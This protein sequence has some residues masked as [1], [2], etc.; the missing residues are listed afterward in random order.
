MRG[1][2]AVAVALAALLM[3]AALCSATNYASSEHMGLLHEIELDR[4]WYEFWEIVPAVYMV[5]NV[6]G[7]PIYI[8][9]SQGDLF[10]DIIAPADS[11]VWREP[12]GVV[13]VVH[14]ETLPP[15]ES[16]VRVLDWDMTDG[17]TWEPITQTGVFVARGWINAFYPEGIF[18]FVD[19]EFLV[20]EPAAGLSEDPTSWGRMKALYR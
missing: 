16:W 18:W 15:G 4:D 1:F 12:M 8:G 6:T 3:G 17:N 5:T 19:V 7:D 10:I 11:L 9:F 14:Y 20:T 2:S 13:P